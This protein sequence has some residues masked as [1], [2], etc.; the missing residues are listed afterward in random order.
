MTLTNETTWVLKGL[1]K[2]G[3]DNQT[4]VN[5]T[6]E[7][8]TLI[9]GSGQAADYLYVEPGS[10]IFALG[11]PNAP[12]IFTSPS[13]GIAG[14]QPKAGDWG[15]IVVSGNAPNNKCLAAPYDCRS[16]F[17]PTLR[18]GGNN[19]HDNSGVIQFVQS[20]YAGYIFTTGR[21]VNS[22]TFQSVGDGTVVHHIQAYR[23]KDDGIEFFGGN[24]GVK[25]AV[26]TEGGDDGLDWDEGYSGH[27]QYVLLQNGSGFGEDN[28]IEASNQ[29]TN[30]DA[31]P[32]AIPSVA[33]L[34]MIGNGQ[35]GYGVYLKE[36]TGG[37]IKNSV[38]VGFK[39]GCQYMTHGPTWA[40]AGTPTALTGT[41]TIDHTLYSCD[42][43]FAQDAA[44][45]WTSEAFFNAQAGNLK[46]DALLQGFLPKAGSPLLDGGA[47]N[48]T[49]A[50]FTPTS[51]IGAFRD[52]NDDWT[53]G[54]TYRLAR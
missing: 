14:G 38:F 16:E 13:D 12:V 34:T 24:V 3:T 42:T 5:L 44:A 27:V 17:D 36:G 31:T 15:G 6:I 4:K 53:Q 10:K 45:P 2:V 50:F 39:K 49:D 29:A 26:V 52:Q 33:N 19:A 21:E 18:Y 11:T 7:P 25:Y 54:W 32:R 37:H 1:V 35:G 47:Q 22:F 46:G 20:R 23:G 8:G 30:Q 43:Q 51:Y 28:G 9:T 48:T 40:A 41:L